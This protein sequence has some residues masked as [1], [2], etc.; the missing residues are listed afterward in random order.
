M[1]TAVIVE[2]FRVDEPGLST[3]VEL[4]IVIEKFKSKIMY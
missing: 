3:N 2:P 4:F 1:G